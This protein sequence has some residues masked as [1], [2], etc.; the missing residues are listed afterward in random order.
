MER[1]RE[2]ERRYGLLKAAQ[3]GIAGVVGFLALEAIL[4]VGLYALY[5]TAAIPSSFASSPSLLALD[6]LASVLGVVVGFFVNEATTVKK[7]NFERRNTALRLLKFE[8]VYAVGSAITIAVQLALLVVFAVSPAIGNIIGAIVAYPVSYIISMRFVWRA[9]P[10][11]R[12]LGKDRGRPQPEAWS[13]RQDNGVLPLTKL[14]CGL[15]LRSGKFRSARVS[16]FELPQPECNVGDSAIGDADDHYP[17]RLDFDSSSYESAS[18]DGTLFP[19]AG[20][21]YALYYDEAFAAE[22]VDPPIGC[23]DGGVVFFRYFVDALAR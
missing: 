8:G 18:E 22:L 4:V 15:A 11:E 20:Q 5:G 19:R 10:L 9:Q 14:D 12:P 1:F 6:V 7:L 2:L 21:D 3:F 17:L 16:A 13:A 23:A